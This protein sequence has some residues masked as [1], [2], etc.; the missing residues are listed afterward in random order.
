MH[1][2]IYQISD[3]K[4]IF[5][6]LKKLFAISLIKIILPLACFNHCT[7]TTHWLKDEDSGI[8]K[9]IR[10]RCRRNIFTANGINK[11]AQM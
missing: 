1:I 2:C 4:D 3:E 7:G 6:L 10:K 5:I 8:K 11:N 9:K